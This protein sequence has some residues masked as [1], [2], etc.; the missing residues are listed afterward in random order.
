RRPASTA[1]PART[2]WRRP[3]G[4]RGTARRGRGSGEGTA[5]GGAG[6]LGLELEHQ[7]REARGP[8]PP[9]TPQERTRARRSIPCS[10]PET[11]RPRPK[12]KGSLLPPCASGQGHP[13]ANSFW[14]A[15]KSKKSRAPSKLKS[16][17][18]S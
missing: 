15:R 4:A 1:A 2:A 7:A 18:V 9:P 8:P 14:N 16:A 13:A 17:C 6:L 5:Q 12:R 11:E 3:S 10:R